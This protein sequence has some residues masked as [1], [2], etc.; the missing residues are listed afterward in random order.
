[1]RRYSPRNVFALLTKVVRPL[2]K[3]ARVST[4]TLKFSQKTL[5]LAEKSSQEASKCQSPCVTGLVGF[6]KIEKVDNSD[7]ED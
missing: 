4:N 5:I 3:A 6:S 7:L 1:M 2:P